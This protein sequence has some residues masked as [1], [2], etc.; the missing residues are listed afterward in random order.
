ME[1]RKSTPVDWVGKE[2]LGFV[3]NAGFSDENSEKIVSWLSGLHEVAPEG[4]YLMKREGLHITVLD[5]VAPLFEYGG[6]DKRELFQELKATYEPAFRR[7]TEAMAPFEVHFG[8]VRVTSGTII[9][10]GRDN[11]QF[12]ALREKFLQSVSLPAGGKQPPNIIH[13]SLARFTPPAI[14]LGPIEE[15]VSSHPLT[16]TQHVSAFRLIEARDGTM[17]DFVVLDSYPLEGVIKWAY[18]YSE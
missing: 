5:W 11:G 3:I 8:E 15:Y 18:D 12:Q 4:M 2:L 13:S 6:V 10:V 1:Q 7:I 14:D 16:I 9:L 17:Q